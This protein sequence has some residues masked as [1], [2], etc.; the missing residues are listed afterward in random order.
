MPDTRDTFKSKAP[1]VNYDELVTFVVNRL[2]TD[3]LREEASGVWITGSFVDPQKPLDTGETPSDLDLLIPVDGWEYPI[4]SSGIVFAAP[5][6]DIPS[7]Y[8][9]E[10]AEWESVIPDMVAETAAAAG[11]AEYPDPGTWDCSAEAVWDR[12]PK[13]VCDTLQRSVE[14]GFHALDQDADRGIV[15]TYDVVIGPQDLFDLLRSQN[16]DRL[17]KLWAPS[18]DGG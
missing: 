4:T 8:G 9:F 10:S 3:R 16:E 14:S 2:L 15:R 6:P 11:P 12:L 18:A 17:L 7:V 5:Q 1:L 13:Y